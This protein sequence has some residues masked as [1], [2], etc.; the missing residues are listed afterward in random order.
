VPTKDPAIFLPA[1]ETLLMRTYTARSVLALVLGLIGFIASADPAAGAVTTTLHF[2][3]LS[4]DSHVHAS[5]TIKAHQRKRAMIADSLY[6][7]ATKRY[8]RKVRLVPDPVATFNQA[9]WQRGSGAFHRT[10]SYKHTFTDVAGV[11]VDDIH[12]KAVWKT[13][14]ATQ[15]YLTCDVYPYDYSHG[16]RAR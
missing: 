16:A 13:K 5:V 14:N 3:C 8:Q 7:S 2:A 1:K 11:P 9:Y 10:R 15:K 6:F 12:F 4:Q